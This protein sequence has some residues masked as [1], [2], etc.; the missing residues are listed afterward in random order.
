M[1]LRE[2]RAVLFDLDGLILDSEPVYRAA[3]QEAAREL[4]FNLTD[5]LYLSLVGRTNEDGEAFLVETFGAGFPVVRFRERWAQLWRH[6]VRRHGIATK[7]GLTELLGLLDAR[8]VPKVVATSSAREDALLALGALAG[9]FDA[10]VS[11]EDVRAGK[12]AP[13]IFLEAAAHVRVPP[14]RCLVL[15]D[16]E[17]GVEAAYAAGTTIIMV[18]D[19]KPP[20]AEAAARVYRVCA[21][22][23]EVRN[24]LAT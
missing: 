21:S 4:G 12:P 23:L 6:R 22:L 16:S 15:E 3:W 7:P 1:S 11:G 8:G 2:M 19:L 14:T 5:Q 20:S 13:D 18:P 10:I 24:L 9:R 17:V